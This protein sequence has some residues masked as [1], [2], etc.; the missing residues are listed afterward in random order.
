MSRF[1]VDFSDDAI[2]RLTMV[3]FD[4]IAQEALKEAA[5]ILE[6]A[7]K[8]ACQSVI[9]HSGDSELVNSW[10]SNDPK[11]TKSHDAYIVNVS[12]KGS[13]KNQY[14]KV[15]GKGGHTTRKYP[16]SNAL[17]A[18]WLENGTA[19]Q[20]PKHFMEKAAKSCEQEVN[21]KI[22]EVFNRKVGAT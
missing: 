11:P 19:R 13:S 7:T 18:I 16:V 1:D 22:E 20:A 8:D 5:P 21:A 15:D 3:G 17:K 14:Y 6:Q 12:P 9:G 10:K 2:T 4:D